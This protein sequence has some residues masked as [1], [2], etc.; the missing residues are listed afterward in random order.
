MTCTGL[1]Q[2]LAVSFLTPLLTRAASDGRIPAITPPLAADYRLYPNEFSDPK[3]DDPAAA[4]LD[5]PAPA[6][7]SN[8]L[9]TAGRM[10]AFPQ[11]VNKRFVGVR[12]VSQI[13]DDH[14]VIAGVDHLA[15]PAAKGG[16]FLRVQAAKK[17]AVL[18]MVALRPQRLEDAGSTLIVGDVV[19]DEVLSP[20]HIRNTGCKPAPTVIGS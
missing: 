17:H 5:A 14:L 13:D 20:G 2:P 15:E 10:I 19:S 6:R 18:K 11:A 12:G 4:P 8:H 3:W 1:G 9:H 7:T 16:E